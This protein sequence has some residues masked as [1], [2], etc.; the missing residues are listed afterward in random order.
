MVVCDIVVGA[1]TL[2]NH[3]TGKGRW[4]DKEQVAS[5]MRDYNRSS[6][7][8]QFLSE[9]RSQYYTI[10]QVHFFPPSFVCPP[11]P[12]LTA[13]HQMQFLGAGYGLGTQI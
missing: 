6:D 2:L 13:C 5:F 12:L 10:R 11:D 7:D 9:K 4:V 1:I 3:I 8:K